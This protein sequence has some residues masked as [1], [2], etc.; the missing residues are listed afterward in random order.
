MSDKTP[1]FI[2]RGRRVDPHGK[3]LG[4]AK[5]VAAE[6]TEGDEGASG[7]PAAKKPAAKAE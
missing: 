6:E 1:E 7:K 2:V 4:P 3:D 5:E